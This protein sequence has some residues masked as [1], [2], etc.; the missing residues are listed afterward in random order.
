MANFRFGA[1][2]G[3]VAGTVLLR[4]GDDAQGQVG[5][6][7]VAVFDFNGEGGIRR[8]VLQREPEG[9]AYARAEWLATRLFVSLPEDNR[10]LIGRMGRH[11]VE[12]DARHAIA[13]CREGFSVP[14]LRTRIQ[15]GILHGKFEPDGIAVQADFGELLHHDIMNAAVEGRFQKSGRDAMENVGFHAVDAR[16][17]GKTHADAS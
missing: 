15:G 5:C 7:G 4:F 13:A 16:C 2:C 6:G 11:V 3:C 14:V 9:A 1:G 10:D 8:E 17:K 12:N